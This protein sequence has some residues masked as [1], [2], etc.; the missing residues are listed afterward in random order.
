MTKMTRDRPNI[1]TMTDVLSS[2]DVVS[3]SS[4][5]Y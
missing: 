2:E 5:G 4:L 1:L 3:M